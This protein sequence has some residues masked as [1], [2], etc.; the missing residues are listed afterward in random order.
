MR[1][2]KVVNAVTVDM[3]TVRIRASARTSS[4]SLSMARSRPPVAWAYPVTCF[5]GPI[6]SKVDFAA[7]SAE[8]DERHEMQRGKVNA[9]A[10]TSAEAATPSRRAESDRTSR[11]AS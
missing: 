4:A 5:R 11:G 8:N 9:V 2:V 6:T 1:P 3:S 7:R 10:G